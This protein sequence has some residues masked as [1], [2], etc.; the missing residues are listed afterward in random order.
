MAPPSI[1]HTSRSPFDPRWRRVG[2]RIAIVIVVAAQ[3]GVIVAAYHNDHRAFGFQMFAESDEFSATIE[4]VLVDG[5]VVA[6]DEDWQ[7]RWR[8][9]VVGRGL[10]NPSPI[11]HS[12][13]GNRTQ[14]SY[15]QEALDWVAANTPADTT[16]RYLQARVTFWENGRGPYSLTLTSRHRELP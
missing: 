1:R 6:V 16:T 3:V 10:S 2:R 15:L 13:R 5:A 12:S 14:F 4:R 8:D 9:L 7:Y 11:H